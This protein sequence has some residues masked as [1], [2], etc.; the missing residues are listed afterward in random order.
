M[1]ELYHEKKHT[2]KRKVSKR[3]DKH[4]E[5]TK[6]KNSR[7]D[8]CQS[9]QIYELYKRPKECKN[10]ICSTKTSEMSTHTKVKRSSDAKISKQENVKQHKTKQESLNYKVN[11]SNLLNSKNK[12]SG[13]DKISFLS[14]MA[15]TFDSEIP[16]N[17]FWNRSKTSVKLIQSLS[18][19]LNKEPLENL[20]QKFNVSNE[21]GDTETVDCKLKEKPLNNEKLIN[22]LIN[23]EIKNNVGMNE[24]IMEMEKET[25]HK[26]SKLNQSRAVL[27]E[28]TNENCNTSIE[29]GINEFSSFD[30]GTSISSSELVSDSI[31]TELLRSASSL[32]LVDP[33]S[34][35]SQ[36]G[37][38]IMTVKEVSDMLYTVAVIFER[39]PDS[40][41]QS[42]LVDLDPPEFL[43]KTVSVLGHITESL[44]FLNTTNELNDE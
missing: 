8:N 34:S 7:S 21:H 33:P 19:K 9:T 39:F 3:D 28:M 2:V 31:S 5:I 44:S 1:T 6:N 23:Q 22:P 37:P 41:K 25:I 4:K 14:E 42:R 35:I 40:L 12:S 36:H 27:Q 16:E 38:S 24:T 43:Y 32:E 20:L 18:S 26:N 10:K 11:K 15:I 17:G 30:K 29:N 13:K